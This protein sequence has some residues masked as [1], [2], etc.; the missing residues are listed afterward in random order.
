MSLAGCRDE[1]GQSW[2][3]RATLDLSQILQKHHYATVT[4][5]A[6]TVD[7]AALQELR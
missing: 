1:T 3:Y 4:A 7:G 6:V 5:A 2:Q